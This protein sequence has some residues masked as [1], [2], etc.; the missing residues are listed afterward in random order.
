MYFSISESV[1]AFACLTFQKQDISITYFLFFSFV[2]TLHHQ[3]FWG[4]L[5]KIQPT[6]FSVRVALDECEEEKWEFN[7]I[8]R[9]QN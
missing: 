7:I 3:S 9:R 2:E 4:R 1:T 8:R 6:Y 5:L